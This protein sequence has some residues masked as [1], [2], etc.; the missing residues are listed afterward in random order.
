[1]T[2]DVADQDG[3]GGSG[4]PRRRTTPTSGRPGSA[5]G[6]ASRPAAGGR[7]SEQNAGGAGG[8]DLAH[9][10]SELAREL[11]RTTEPAEVMSR[12]ARAAVE[13]VPGAQ[14]GSITLV[15]ARRRVSAEGSTGPLPVLFDRLQEET[16]QGPCLD[17]A[18]EHETVRVDD[19]A[20]EP[21]W[22]ELGRRASAA[23][24]RSALCL[25]L[26][27]EGGDLGALNLTSRAPAAFGDESEQV[28][29]LLSSHAAVAVSDALQLQG[30]TRA[31]AN[32][33]VIGQAK[34]ILMERFKITPQQAF[35]QLTQV[36]QQ[37]NR[38]LVDVAEHLTTTGHLG[39]PGG[40]GGGPG[41]P[42][43]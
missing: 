22:P 16:G 1:M 24:V 38:K 15:H 14:E 8:Q 41:G 43:R 20:T 36:S 6:V 4:P 29:L 9:R 27:V 13:M 26:F 12:V 37:S 7:P 30:T 2:V 17:A 21:R 25:Q 19:F 39:V 11:H 5:S 35:D 23:G 3:P 18:F 40:S 31:L 28:A 42:P 33:D 34:G 32:R 10:L